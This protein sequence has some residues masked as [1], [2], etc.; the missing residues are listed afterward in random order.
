MDESL[1][2]AAQEGN[3]VELYASIRRDG[4]VL[5]HIDEIEFVDTPLHIAAAQGCIDFAMEIMILKPSFARKLNQEGLS[6]I[7]LAVEKGHKELALHLMQ[8]DKNLVRVKGKQGETALHYAI[9]REQNFDLLARFLEACPECIRDMTTTNQTALHIATRHNRL[10]ALELLCRMLRKSDYCEDVVNQ[11][12]RN[13]DTA[14]HIAARNNQP[15][16]LKLLLKCKA[17][18]HATNQ[19][20][21]TALDVANEVNNIESINILHGWGSARVLSFKYKIQKQMVKHVTKASEV[22]FQGMDSIS[23]EDRNALLVILGLLLTATY[24]ASISPPGSVWQGDGSSNSNS[25]VGHREKLPG[26]S[27]MDQVNFLIFYI[28]AYTVFI[29]AFFLTLGLLKP[30]PHGFRTCLQVLLA[31]LAISFD[32]SIT[33]LAPTN[34]AY[35]VMCLFSTLVFALMMVMCVAYRVSKI[36]VLFLG[37]WLVPGMYGPFQIGSYLILGCWL[38]LSLYDPFW[39]GSTGIVGCILVLNRFEYVWMAGVIV[40][41]PIVLLSLFLLWIEVVR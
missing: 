7:H 31:F 17:D 27:V 26:K 8:N 32:E 6:P 12:D 4:N 28:P 33:F 20:G 38:F 16:M 21:S 41:G 19:G 29:V 36:S 30:F 2:R 23:S 1:K 9:T 24:Q 11:K 22:I 5:R 25:T 15:M 18:K 37:C 39:I 40:S 13:G 14:L 10:E 34:L 3:I 35:L